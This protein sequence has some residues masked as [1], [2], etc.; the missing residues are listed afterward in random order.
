MRYISTRGGMAPIGFQDAVM[1]GLADDGGLLVPE[2]LPD[3]RDRLD[4]WSTLGYTDLA[5]EI[6][7]LFS[8]LPEGDLRDLVDRSYAGFRHPEVAPVVQVGDLRVVELFHGPTLA[9]KD[10]ALQFLSNAFE[11]I[12]DRRDG[13]L[14]ILG[15]TSGDTGSAAI[16]GVRGRDRIRIFIMHPK[17]RVSP[18]QERQMTS[19]LDDNVFNLAIEGSFDDCQHIMKS[20]FEDTGFKQRHALGAINS[21]NWARVLA[22]VV[23]F[24]YAG[25]KVRKETGAARVRFSVPTGNF[26]D[27]LA[28][29]YAARMGL[30]VGKLVVA[31]NENDILTRFFTSGIYRKGTVVPT[32]SP[33]MDIQVASNF[34]RYLFDRVNRDPA[35]L[36]GLMNDF[37]TTGQIRLP[38]ADG[39]GVDPMFHAGAGDTRRTL[40]T[41]RDTWRSHGYLLDPH[42]AVGVAVARECLDPDEPMLCLATAHP[43]KFNRAIEDAL[44]EDLAHHEILDA[45]ADAETRC[46]SLPADIDAVRGYLDLHCADR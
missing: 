26:G 3:V 39:N 6:F 19:V 37:R 21:V 4:A 27:V 25:L 18:L 1:T 16:H 28:G 23:Y 20:L 2:A 17:G 15:A 11:Y 24:F 42:T 22:Q 45:L 43:A 29:Y 32:I 8:D 13:H 40:E 14:N 34:E 35:A 44:G 41:I 31:T 33:S 36:R 12:L 5:F 9:F 38:L 10:I 7:R 46:D 30:P